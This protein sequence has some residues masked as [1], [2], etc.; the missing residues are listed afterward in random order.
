MTIS[1]AIDEINTSVRQKPSSSTKRT[2]WDSPV[3]WQHESALLDAGGKY[4][5]DS[6]IIHLIDKFG[7]RWIAVES[8]DIGRN[9]AAYTW[10]TESTEGRQTYRGKMWYSQFKELFP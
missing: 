4:G 10:Y 7:V 9:A 3:S 2:D 8:D 5:Y 6:T 1:N